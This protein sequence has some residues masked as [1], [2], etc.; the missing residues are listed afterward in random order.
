MYNALSLTGV[1]PLG[2]LPAAV[3]GW[4]PTIGFTLHPHLTHRVAPA[5]SGTLTLTLPMHQRQ[6]SGVDTI[7]TLVS[8]HEN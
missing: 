4:P 6:V 5:Q 2:A 7:T 3:A 1:F 8:L